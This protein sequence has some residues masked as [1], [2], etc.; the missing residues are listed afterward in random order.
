LC[1]AGR[2]VPRSAAHPPYCGGH[3][4]ATP[5]AAAGRTTNATSWSSGCANRDCPDVTADAA[6]REKIAAA[7]KGKPRPAHVGEVLA[8]SLT[9]RPLSEEHRRK[10]SAAHRRRGTRPPKAGRPWTAAEDELVRSLP[11][12]EAA[13]KTG[14][15][16]SAVYDR[17]RK[18]K[19]P[20]GR[21]GRKIRR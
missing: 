14:R 13:E 3:A 12:P 2:R 9:G 21:A 1:P 20:D 6:R 17:R 8:A 19:L 7:K 11:P 16:L 5:A 10:L 15:P 4:W 18:L